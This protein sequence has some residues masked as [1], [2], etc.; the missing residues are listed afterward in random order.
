MFFI[1]VDPIL[2][3]AKKYTLSPYIVEYLSNFGF[4]TLAHIKR[5]SWLNLSDSYW[6]NAREL[7]LSNNWAKEWTQYINSLNIAGIR[8]CSK[9]NELVWVGN[10]VS[11]QVYAKHA[12]FVLADNSSYDVPK[13]CFDKLWKWKLPTKLKCN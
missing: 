13:W 1:D 6:L 10:K 11:R 8:L 5:P 9:N 12:Y 4:T 2:G 3:L 7:G